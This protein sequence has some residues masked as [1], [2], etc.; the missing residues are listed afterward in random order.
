[1]W[2]GAVVPSA[3]THIRHHHDPTCSLPPDTSPQSWRGSVP[4]G[5]RA[6]AGFRS[7][8]ILRTVSSEPKVQPRR[9]ADPNQTSNEMWNFYSPVPKI[10]RRRVTS[11]CTPTLQC[12]Y[13]RPM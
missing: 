5:D 2:F 6:S 12:S 9:M 7:N 1:M 3:S 10:L 4:L 8:E 13:S 11:R